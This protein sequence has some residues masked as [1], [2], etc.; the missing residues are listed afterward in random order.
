MRHEDVQA[1]L[2]AKR[3]PGAVLERLEDPKRIKG[4][5][6]GDGASAAARDVRGLVQQAFAA[7]FYERY[8]FFRKRRGQFGPVF[9]KLDDAEH[10][11]LIAVMLPHLE[12][13][14]ESA[15]SLLAHRPYQEGLTRKPFRS[16][17]SP[18][19]LA[20][21]R[22]RWL[23]RVALLVGEY[24]A[25]ITWVA[26]W[27]AHLAGW[28][29]AVDLG[30]LLAGAIDAGGAAGDEV[31]EILKTS[32]TGEHEVGQMGRHVTQALLSCSR[33]DAWAFVERLLLSA[34]RQEGLRQAILESVDEAHPEAFRRMLRL[35]REE[36]L[37]RFSSVV[38]AA[39]TWFGFLW[40]GTSAVQIDSILDRVLLFLED[41]AARAAALNQQDAETVYL[42]L[43]SQAFEDVDAAVASATRLLSSA[44]ADI[45]FVAT[46]LLAQSLWTSALPPLVDVLDDADLRVAACALDVFGFDATAWVDGPRLLS[47]LEALMGRLKKRSQTL[48]AI[49]WPWWSWKLGRPHVAAAMAA[50]AS[51]ADIDRLLPYAA[52]LDPAG[53]AAL[54]RRIAGLRAEWEKRGDETEREPAEQSAPLEGAVRAAVLEFLGDASPDVRDVAFRAMERAPLEAD[55]VDRLIELLARK[56]G[57]LRAA[58]LARLRRLGDADLLS[59]ADRLLADGAELRRLAGLELLRDAAEAGRVPEEVRARITR[60]RAEHASLSEQERSHI[61]AVLGP[62]TA[63]AS[64]DDALGLIAPASLRTWPEPRAIRLRLDTP[65][66]RASLKSLAEL[67]LAHQTTEIRNASG[68]VRL[69][70]EISYWAVVPRAAEELEEQEKA[71]PLL[72]VWRRWALD[73]DRRRDPDGLE[74]LRALM[75]EREGPVWGAPVVRQVTGPYPWSAGRE[76]LRGLIGWGIV[77]DPPARAI[78]FLLDGL[79]QAL[80]TFTA[81]DYERLAEEADAAVRTLVVYSMYS[82]ADERSP[83]KAKL[84]RAVDWLARAR[85]WRDLF[86]SSVAP[87]HAE[88]L[89]GLLRGFQARSRGHREL[90]ITLRDFLDA[91]RAGAVGT[92]E[93]V[94]LLVGR[95]SARSYPSL[96]QAVST[97]NVSK[98]L[99]AFPELVD[100][101]AR[102][103]QR[104]VEVETQRGDRSTAASRLARELRWTGGLETLSRALPALGADHF[105][106]T[107]GWYSGEIPRRDTLSHLILRSTPREQDTPEA[108]AEWARGA[109][110]SESRL[111]ELAVYA[112]Q[113]AAHVEHVLG[114]SGLE[115]AVWWMHAHTKDHRSWQLAELKEIWAAEVSE[116]TPLSAADLLERY[117]ILQRFRRES[118]KFGSQRQQS[119]GRAVAIGLANLART[120]GY[121][122]P[123][124]LQWAM[125]R[126][127]VADLA[128]GPVIV[129]RGDVAVELSIDADGTPSLAVRKADRLLKSIPASLKKDPEVTELRARLQELRRQGSRVRAAL[130]EAMCR[131]DGF[132][133]SELWELIAHPMLGPALRRL[134]FVGDG[135]AGYLVQDGRALRDHA[136]T[137]HPVGN[138]EPLRIAHPHDLFQRGDWAA[139]QR[140][141]FQAERVQPFKQVFREYYPI[142]EAE[143]EARRSRRYAGHQVNPRQALALLGGRGWVAR[144]EEGVSR[145]FHEA[146][147][148]AR[149][150]FQ[151]A[152]YTPADV[153]GLTLEEVVFTRKG[154]WK[155]LPFAD[156]PARIFSETM[157]DLDLVVAV[158][159]QGGVDPE[160]TA[161]TIEMRAAL[162]RET[163]ELLRLD[164]VEVQANYAIVRGELATYSV[165]L[166]SAGVLIMPGT[167]LPIVAVHS[168][169]R[170]RLFLPF[171]DDDPR[172]A[173]VLSKVL[174]L[175]RDREIRDPSI[176][177]RI[178]A[179]SRGDRSCGWNAGGGF[180][181]M[182]FAQAVNGGKVLK[183]PGPD[184]RGERAADCNHKN[185]IASVNRSL[186]T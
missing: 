98:E 164:N 83:L 16:P 59:A 90:G 167:S 40:D 126:E 89:Y 88:R 125:E 103:R 166:G 156:I 109:G 39:D 52:D 73:P 75:A 169:H 34:Q 21:V 32:A 48:D 99:A 12:A 15:W 105:A 45:R 46:H 44:S 96:L 97:R 168:Q 129:R 158:A 147:V 172:T 116:R 127:A 63:A 163:C 17:Q 85:W 92:D 152:F 41:P 114:W 62:Q 155:E 173:E 146:G 104:I 154:E 141:C 10:R 50:N 184:T 176:L 175:A 72:D 150:G 128:Q 112:P 178:R 78:D 110:I 87:A 144:P 111:L 66:A 120:A 25:D 151:E 80:S 106:R 5:L 22:G 135:T 6:T 60:Y 136:G 174:L 130:E 67:V 140:E 170:G 64:T 117:E 143:R 177:D 77:W 165:H 51:A 157:R 65:A 81:D 38:R 162:L 71:L 171:A 53:R 55:E 18:E 1:V 61:D 118:R 121:R 54:I 161:S 49:V 69:L 137:L 82:A 115:N 142:T 19:T 124:R 27:A 43:W 86:P 182:L 138:E 181:G 153:E 20:D 14:I 185:P 13:E 84:A 134:I 79:E 119:E 74:L 108:F 101:V 42:A 95:W 131:G 70:G 7:N 24:D 36:K 139:W 133:G 180:G 8:D 148:T 26:A 30:W 93:F 113:W 149:L 35:I 122:D 29:D 28:M 145:T 186:N 107:M 159:H 56:P 91:Y 3:R 33:P 102:C 9:A 76:I 23:L 68:E 100:A 58:C 2:D 37:T 11:R 183:N 57:D 132:D 47:R 94:D 4:L 123:Q 160:A 31:F 179:V